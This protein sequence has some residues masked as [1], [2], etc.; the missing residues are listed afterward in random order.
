V[1][2]LTEPENRRSPSYGTSRFEGSGQPGPELL[3]IL[4]GHI[5]PFRVGLEVEPEDTDL[6]NVYRPFD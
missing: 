6:T 2:D 5:Q 3:R 4:D 1:A